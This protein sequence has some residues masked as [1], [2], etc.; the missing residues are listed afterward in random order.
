MG[1]AYN[2]VFD[3][4]TNSVP[5]RKNEVPAKYR[6]VEGVRGRSPL[7]PLFPVS[8]REEKQER[9]IVESSG[10][11][12]EERHRRERHR[13]ETWGTF[14]T[15]SRPDCSPSLYRLYRYNK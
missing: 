2:R 4:A 11:E 3:F 14:P 9:K 12:I 13:E 8:R 6:Q 15:T 5:F 1:L 7:M 10:R